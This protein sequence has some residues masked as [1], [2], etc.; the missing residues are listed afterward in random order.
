MTIIDS[1]SSAIG[2]KG[3]KVEVELA[4]VI[5]EK[6]DKNA[7]KELVENLK[8]KNKKIQSDCIKVLYETSYM[9]P[10]LIEDYYKDFLDLLTSKNNRLVWGGMVA[11]MMITDSKHKEIFS[12]F[13]LIQK[14][15]EGGSVITVDCGV[16]IFAKL[17]KYGEYTD[18][19]DPILIE[20]LWKCPIKQLP[21]YMEKSVVSIKEK[22]KEIY[23]NIIEQRISECDKESQIKR[24]NKI[25]KQIEKLS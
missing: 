6:E 18:K 22:N 24:L 13:N 23:Q 3:N 25:L 21:Q 2:A 5:A 9:K 1:L 14:T 17:N 19:V 11:I 4:K 8:N 10:N 15:I 16:G 20:L 7:I 12:E